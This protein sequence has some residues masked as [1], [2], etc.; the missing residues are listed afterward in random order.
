MDKTFEVI[1]QTAGVQADGSVVTEESLIYL[2]QQ[3]G[4]C[5]R[6]RRGEYRGEPD[7]RPYVGTMEGLRYDPARKA[8]V[9]TLTFLKE[10]P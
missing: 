7:R 6:V 8:L 2:A 3:T 10:T 9:G 1:L 4:R 5:Y